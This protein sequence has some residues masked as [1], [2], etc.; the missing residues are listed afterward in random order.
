[1]R[2]VG[3]LVRPLPALTAG[4]AKPAT[5]PA[6]PGSAKLPV[7]PLA[8][9]AGAIILVLLGAGWLGRR[10][11]RAAVSAAAPAAP[12]SQDP[13]QADQPGRD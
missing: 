3:E 7:V 13:P 11:R 2:P 9:G 6:T 10:R 12:S 8:T 1:V 4:R 5:R